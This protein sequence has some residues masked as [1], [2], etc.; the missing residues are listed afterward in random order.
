MDSYDC[1]LVCVD[2]VA[3]ALDVNRFG[4]D[5]TVL[6]VYDPVFEHQNPL[7][8]NVLMVYLWLAA[9]FSINYHFYGGIGQNQ[10]HSQQESKRK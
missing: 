10:L 8:E 2:F 7:H 3:T 9:T 5:G 4:S 6:S 1:D